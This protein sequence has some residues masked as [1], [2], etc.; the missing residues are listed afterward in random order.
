MEV[1]GQLH[2]LAALFPPTPEERAPGT[3]WISGWV[4]PRADLDDME[5][6]KLLTLPTGIEQHVIHIPRQVRTHN[7]T[8]PTVGNSMLF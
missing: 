8:A 7:H 4:I 1:S 6:L 2:A 3:H 5:K